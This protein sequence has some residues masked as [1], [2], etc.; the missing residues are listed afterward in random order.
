MA[1]IIGRHGA[2]KDAPEHMLDPSDMDSARETIIRALFQAGWSVG[3]IA[4]LFGKNRQ[5]AARRVWGGQH[6]NAM[7]PKELDGRRVPGQ[8]LGAR[9]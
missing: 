5:W 9:G 3:Q 7:S 6:A 2:Q 1:S 8:A 4:R